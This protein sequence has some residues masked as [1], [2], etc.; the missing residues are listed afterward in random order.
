MVTRKQMGIA[1]TIGMAGLAVVLAFGRAP[2]VKEPEQMPEALPNTL[3][4]AAGKVEPLSEEVRLGLSMTGKLAEV[5]V[6]EG[7]AVH[8]GQVLARLENADWKARLAEAEATVHIRE[9]ELARVLNGARQEERREA[10]AAVRE[11]DAVV[12]QTAR[13]LER[14]SALGQSGWSSRQ[15]LETTRRDHQVALAKQAQAR[16]HLAV[17]AA[18]A[19][20]DER[21]RAEATLELARAQRD[22]AAAVLAKTEIVSPLEG[23]VLRRHR[24]VG[25]MI[26]EAQDMPILSIGDVSVL[27]VRAEVDETDIAR[28]KE[29]QPAWVHADAF[30][31]ARFAGHVSRLGAM[32]GRKQVHTDQPTEKLDNKV[33]EALITLD[34]HPPLPVGLRVDAFIETK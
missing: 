13:D 10:E 23:V 34:G 12:D 8:V 11:A 32:V 20:D 30:G 6:D 33:L 28:L 1:A 19:R 7:D 14:Y 24:R 29:G 22:E 31:G 17:V 18:K 2:S 25:E 16:Q 3:I 9:A 4:S 15:T 26:S 27:R 5:L 21:E